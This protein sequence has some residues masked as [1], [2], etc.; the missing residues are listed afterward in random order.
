MLKFP[1]LAANVVL[2]AALA[3]PA[4][5]APKIVTPQG[6]GG[7]TLGARYT[8]LRA[9]GLVG[10]IG[11]GCEAAGPQAR[12]AT[13]SA[14]LQGSV[15]FTFTT[16]RRVKTITVRGGAAARSIHVGSTGNALRRAFPSARFDHSSDAL[17]GAT[18]VSVPRHGG[19]PLGF[20]VSA[21]TQ[22]VQL[23]AVPSVVACE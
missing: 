14:P 18:F 10:P 15:D 3:A 19:G 23:I 22:R 1:A 21:T 6:V 16:P 13:L 12:S 20:T 8:T 9:M 11:L 4:F 7:V 2:I 5:A 17:F